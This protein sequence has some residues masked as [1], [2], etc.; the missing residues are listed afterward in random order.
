MSVR[1][2]SLRGLKAGQRGDVCT[3]RWG[4]GQCGKDEAGQVSGDQT[5]EALTC[6]LG[7]GMWPLE[8]VG[9]QDTNAPAP[10]SLP[11]PAVF[12][13]TSQ[14][15]CHLVGC[16]PQC[17]AV[18]KRSGRALRA[19]FWGLLFYPASCLHWPST[20]PLSSA[21]TAQRLP[22]S[23]APMADGHNE[24]HGDGRVRGAL[25]L[26]QAPWCLL[27]TPLVRARRDIVYQRRGRV[28]PRHEGLGTPTPVSGR[29]SRGRTLL[30]GAPCAPHSPHGGSDSCGRGLAC[31]RQL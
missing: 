30:A 26:C 14:W 17:G 31:D 5:R 8:I 10:G 4:G 7:A 23:W 24:A 27:P 25:V 21:R 2:Q 20:G 9:G 1:R 29:G 15:T 18:P 6:V 3:L 12:R 19:P 11:A 28:A 13:Q 22:N 16:V